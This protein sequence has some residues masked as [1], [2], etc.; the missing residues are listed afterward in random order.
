MMLKML[1]AGFKNT[2]SLLYE[3]STVP[4]MIKNS[5][6][7]WGHSWFPLAI[8]PVCQNGDFI[9]RGSNGLM[10]L[11]NVVPGFVIKGLNMMADNPYKTIGVA[12]SAVL[13]TA[14]YCH[15]QRHQ[16]AVHTKRVSEKSSALKRFDSR[17]RR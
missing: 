11:E 1:A 5:L 15:R 9:C 6:Q 16:Q 8:G 12:G 13:L 17:D 4:T 3:L 7:S 14:F 2:C 10:K